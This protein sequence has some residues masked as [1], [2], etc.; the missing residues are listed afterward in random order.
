MY[1]EVF[2]CVNMQNKIT[3]E[4]E[5][6]ITLDMVRRGN[7]FSTPEDALKSKFVIVEKAKT[8]RVPL[9]VEY[10]A[11]DNYGDIENYVEYGDSFDR[12]NYE[13]GNYFTTLKDARNSHRY[14]TWNEG[15]K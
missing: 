9:K 3:P 2:Y 13:I 1:K 4:V 12:V 11:V 7:K 8:P 14:K 6:N 5:N 15:V 10:Y